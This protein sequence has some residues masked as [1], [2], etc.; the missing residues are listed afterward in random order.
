M[1]AGSLK[2]LNLEF[3][4]TVIPRKY[5]YYFH[6]R[7]EEFGV[8]FGSILDKEMK[9]RTLCNTQLYYSLY[10][11]DTRTEFCWILKFPFQLL[12]I[13]D[14]YFRAALGMKEVGYCSRQ[15]NWFRFILWIS[16]LRHSH[17]LKM[18]YRKNVCAR[19]RA[20]ACVCVCLCVCLCDR[21]RTQCLN[22]LTGLVQIRYLESSCKYL[23]QFFFLV[24]P[25][26]KIKDSS[27]EKKLKILIFSKMALTILIKFVGL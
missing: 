19:A 1:A 21:L 17:S 6:H 9:L 13:Y 8:N 26:P 4:L 2:T 25:Y 7:G 15:K 22:H 5:S 12:K 14:F 11:R 23:K 24:F 27:H 10:L 3:W 18:C 16:I 20:R